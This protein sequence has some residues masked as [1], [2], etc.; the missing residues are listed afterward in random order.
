MCLAANFSRG[1]AILLVHEEE[2][3][4]LVDCERE[5]IAHCVQ[6]RHLLKNST[7]LL[8]ENS[9]SRIPDLSSILPTFDSNTSI[10][11][12]SFS[13]CQFFVKW[14][15]FSSG[16]HTLFECAQFPLL[17]NQFVS[18]IHKYY[19]RQDPLCI[20]A[21]GSRMLLLRAIVPLSVQ[22]WSWSDNCLTL[23]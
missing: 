11:K 17:E 7:I 1:L 10:T 4:T 20:H 16:L 9:S 15:L 13:I 22:K 5:I 19:F 2:E 18:S 21:S 12:Y 6:I 3:I 8:L 14:S 23:G